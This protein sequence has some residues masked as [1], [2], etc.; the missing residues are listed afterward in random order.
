[1]RDFDVLAAAA[2]IAA[3]AA[4]AGNTLRWTMLLSTSLCGTDPAHRRLNRRCMRRHR[5]RS[6]RHRTS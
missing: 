1:M 5:E 6:L 2:T 4:A 3:A